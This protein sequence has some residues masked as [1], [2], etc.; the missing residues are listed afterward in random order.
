MDMIAFQDFKELD[1]WSRQ[2]YGTL[3]TNIRFCG[4]D[5][6]SIVFTSTLA[7]EGKSEVSFHVAKG[8]AEAGKK[9]VYID[10][11]IRHQSLGYRFCVNQEVFGLSEFLREEKNVLDILYKSKINQLYLI[12]AGKDLGD[13]TELLEKAHFK[14]LLD[15]LSHV[16][17]FI[18]IDGASMD[19]NIDSAIIA[20][21]CDGSVIV[22]EPGKV[23]YKKSQ[24]MIE[25]L[26]KSNCKI[27]GCVFNKPERKKKT[28]YWKKLI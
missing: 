20:K 24:K 5:I 18:I 22:M 7:K 2:A 17:D 23:S 9:V 16:F 4:D 10:A 25:Q 12:F 1:Y 11:N 26:E 14:A 27:L 13:A 3:R 8:L 28:T 15:A 6:K 21:E 19:N